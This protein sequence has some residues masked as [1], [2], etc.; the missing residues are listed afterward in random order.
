MTEDDTY[1]AL[2]RIKFED[3]VKVI[4]DS[5]NTRISKTSLIKYFVQ[6][7]HTEWAAFWARNLED[8]NTGWTLEQFALECKRRWQAHE[9]E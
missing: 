6:Y 8:R 2:I 9:R 4:A 5:I 7:N 3:A 1:N